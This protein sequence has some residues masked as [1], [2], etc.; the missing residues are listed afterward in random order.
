MKQMQKFFLRIVTIT[1]WSHLVIWG[2]CVISCKSYSWG[3]CLQAESA[4]ITKNDKG[5][6]N[7]IVKE[8]P[9]K[10]KNNLHVE[11]TIPSLCGRTRCVGP[12]FLRRVTEQLRHHINLYR[13]S[14]LIFLHKHLWPF[15]SIFGFQ[16]HYSMQAEK[17]KP[18]DLK[19]SK[20][21]LGDRAPAAT[22]T[23]TVERVRRAGGNLLCGELQQRT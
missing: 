15:L 10:R 11:S 9:R 19:I 13:P 22:N 20:A 6:E 14:L 1:I 16:C 7:E 21:K 8:C 4:W 2:Q 12:A 5:G 17:D 23:T 18:R 3:S